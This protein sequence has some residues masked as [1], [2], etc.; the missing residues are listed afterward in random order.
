MELNAQP[1]LFG[2]YLVVMPV[3]D[4]VA[5]VFRVRAH[6]RSQSEDVD[7]EDSRNKAVSGVGVV[8]RRV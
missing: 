4:V 1:T 3:L 5:N 7:G 6:V 2:I 8:T